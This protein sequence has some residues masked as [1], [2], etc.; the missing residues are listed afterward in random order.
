M[1][2]A[3]NPTSVIVVNLLLPQKGLL[4]RNYPIVTFEQGYWVMTES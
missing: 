2:F 3:L 1:S 4:N